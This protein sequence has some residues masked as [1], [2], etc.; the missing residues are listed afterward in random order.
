LILPKRPDIVMELE[1]RALRMR[2]VH[3]VGDEC[4]AVTSSPLKAADAR[5]KSFFNKEFRT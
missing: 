1:A 3:I 5:R 2:R 4:V